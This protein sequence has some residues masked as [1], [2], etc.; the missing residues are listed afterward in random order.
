[1]VFLPV[2]IQTRFFVPW[3]PIFLVW[4]SAALD[5]AGDWLGRRAGRPAL[6]HAPAAAAALGLALLWP[7]VL[8]QGQRTL[9]LGHKAMG[10]WLRQHGSPDAVLMTRDPAVALYADRVS[11]RCPNADLDA[12][13]GYARRRGASLW[14]TDEEELTRIKPH[15]APLLDPRRRPP[16]MTEVYRAAPDE[17]VNLVLRLPASE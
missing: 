8:V 2:R 15:L 4:A 7:P 13:L 1:L 11:I 12:I 5:L 9:A 14:A 16:G 17:G 10:L 6:R 3:V